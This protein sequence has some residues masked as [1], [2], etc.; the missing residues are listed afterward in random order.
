MAMFQ[1]TPK[2]P[3]VSEALEGLIYNER[4]T[5]SY[6]PGQDGHGL[7]LVERL[8]LLRALALI[9]NIA[10]VIVALIFGYV[11]YGVR[12][13]HPPSVASGLISLFLSFYLF[14][15]LWLMVNVS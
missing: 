2:G 7:M 4:E 5:D 12:L 1:A 10:F 14:L 9:S 13:N 3:K 6:Q 11:D 15:N 8:S